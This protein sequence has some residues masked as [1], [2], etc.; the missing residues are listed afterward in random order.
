[1]SKEQVIQ[2][3]PLVIL[4][5]PLLSAILILLFTSK[6]RRL[7]AGISVGA[8]ALGLGASIFLFVAESNNVG[9]SNPLY[10]WLSIGPE[11][12]PLVFDISLQNDPLS[13][14]MLLVVTL[15]GTLV[16]VFSLVY[17]RQDQGHSR[18][19]G[20]L[21]FFMFSMLGIV[22]SANLVMMFIFWELVGVSSYL[23]ISH[24]FEKPAAADAGKKAFITNRI[25]DV[26]FLLGI[27]LV[28]QQTGS[29]VFD[30]LV[31]VTTLAGLLI[32]CG[33]VGKSAQFPLHVWLPDAMEGPT[34]VSA[35]I[36]AATMVAAGVYMICRVFVLFTPEALEIIAWT[37]AVT[38][39]LA[40]LIAVQQN[41]IKRI[42][43]YS[44]LSQLGYMVMA[45]GCGGPA[46]SMFH[47][48]THAAFKA[49]LFLGAGAVIYACHHEQNI[50]K[51][52]NLKNKMGW[53][54]RTFVIGALALSGFPLFSGFFSKDAILMQAYEHQMPL[55]IIGVFVAFLTAFYMTRCVIVTFFGEARSDHAKE[56]EE[57]P[58]EMIVPLVILALL[59][60]GLGWEFIGLSSF[61]EG[62]FQWKDL[63]AHS[64]AAHNAAMIGGTIAVAIG[65][66]AG[67][68]IYHGVE[69][70]P[71]PDK[72]KDVAKWMGDKFYFDELYGAINQWTQEKM[73]FAADWFDRW[74]IAGLGVK[75]TSGAVDITGC[76][77]RLFQ[78]G[79]VQTY[80]LLTVIGL[81]FILA[82][83]LF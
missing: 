1:M 23:L 62:F 65:L 28:W 52:G 49:L 35:L 43:A 57:V 76:L 67:W 51:L 12:K 74:I 2:Y 39:L 29:L 71:L 50:W 61:T 38:A 66:I 14:L 15:V 25:G 34:P 22:L 46:A 83:I 59:S 11:V 73:S 5:A 63:A 79:N 31:P 33:A 21:S 13:R 80:A 68:K 72:L 64:D 4:L 60:I 16:H 10:T 45:V 19:F 6:F 55:F 24:W 69:S 47:L 7:S 36:H 82:L 18:Y 54:S 41:D 77:L 30:S 56:A 3:L 75:G 27:L 20:A 8:V 37:G 9:E 58:G 78:T 26:G 42:L 70:D 17:M 48:T 44:T 40:A 32:F 81:L 53:T